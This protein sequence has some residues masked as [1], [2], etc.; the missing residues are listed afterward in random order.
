MIFGQLIDT[1]TTALLKQE[2][3]GI[4]QER[5]FLI[6]QNTELGN[7]QQG[8]LLG[9]G[10]FH[11]DSL[12]NLSGVTKKPLHF[13]L[14]DQGLGFLDRLAQHEIDKQRLTQGLAQF[15][16]SCTS[17]QDVRDALPEMVVKEIPMLSALPRTRDEAWQIAGDQ[18]RQDQWDKT[19]ELI[20]FHFANRMLY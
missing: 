11:K 9:E 5:D 3:K 8:F 17:L 20:L 13:S 14:L 6:D 2:T 15:L 1:L 19:R 7:P 10:F 16:K 12:T 4:A 18:K